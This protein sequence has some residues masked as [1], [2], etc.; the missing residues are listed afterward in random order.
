[1][2]I[3]LAVVHTHAPQRAEALRH[4]V[5]HLFP[6]GEGPIVRQSDTRYRCSRW[7]GRSGPGCHA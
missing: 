6:G 2:S 5:Q 3:K 4:Q 1:M 7:P